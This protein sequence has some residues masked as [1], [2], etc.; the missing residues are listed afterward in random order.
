MHLFTQDHADTRSFLPQIVGVFFATFDPVLGPTVLH[1][2]PERLISSSASEPEGR[3]SPSISRSRSVSRTRTRARASSSVSGPNR[4]ASPLS[5]PSPAATRETTPTLTPTPLPHTPTPERPP[6]R[7]LPALLDFSSMSEYV[8]P[9]S[10]LQGKL[11]IFRTRGNWAEGEDSDDEE[12]DRTHEYKVMGV[13][14]VVE[15]DGRYKRN[16]YMWN[17]CFVFRA[18]ASVEAFEPV[19]RKTA[20]ILRSAEVKFNDVVR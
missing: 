6:D 5:L 4:T 17:T 20:R 15:V 19:V 9:K 10:S 11:V 18:N 8:I 12:E 3:R 16:Q 1:Q 2:V 14:S 13:P 7:P